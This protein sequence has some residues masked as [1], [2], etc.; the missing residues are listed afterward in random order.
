[1]KVFTLAVIYNITP[2]G[3]ATQLGI[4]L[5]RATA[6]RER[7]LGMFPALARALEE[8]S[9]YGAIRGHAELC[10]GLRRQRARDGRPS[11]WEVNWLR[12]TPVQGSA[13]VVF[14]V[15]GNRLRRRYQHLG[16][17]LVLPMH[18]AFVFECPRAKL[19]KVAALTREVMR[20]AVQEFFP[21]LVPQVDVN[22]AEPGCWNKDG[23]AR[24]LELW[25]ED[26]EGADR[27][28]DS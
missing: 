5:G 27:Y 20:G 4:G 17:R 22:I 14:K 3:L 8:A 6:E 9:A 1:M 15:A 24:S 19:K 16:A 7:F 2:A 13:S 25:R 10:T 28:L 11:P 18:D 21:M 12:N 26:I 23:K